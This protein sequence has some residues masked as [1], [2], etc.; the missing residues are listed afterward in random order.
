MKLPVILA[1][2][3]TATQAQALSCMRP[4]AAAS[5]DQASASEF[6]YLVLTGILTAPP[7][8]TTSGTTPMSLLGTITGHGLT[9]EG[10]SAPYDGDVVLQ[11]TCAGPWCGSVPASGP[12]LAF[13]RV[14]GATPVI[15]L[16]ACS[17]W[18]FTAPDQA[19]LDRMTTCMQGGACSAQAVQ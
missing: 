5:F 1:T 15:E 4:D 8:S 12:V 11:V 14:D 17:S 10:F 6:P 7:A 18:L 9:A 13:A 3:L 19:T 16:D 2:L